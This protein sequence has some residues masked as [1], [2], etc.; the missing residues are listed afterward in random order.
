MPGRAARGA[1]RA[2][3]HVLFAAPD[4]CAA[5]RAGVHA[6]DMRE[7][8]RSSA[9]SSAGKKEAQVGRAVRSQQAEN[10]PIEW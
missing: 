4:E 10:H 2:E 1:L 8:R 5:P 3:G 7:G 6:A 9:T